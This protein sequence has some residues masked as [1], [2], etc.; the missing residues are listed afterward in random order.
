MGLFCL[1]DRRVTAGA[2]IPGVGGI[3]APLKGAAPHLRHPDHRPVFLGHAGVRAWHYADNH[4][5]GALWLLYVMI[6]VWGADSGAYMFGK[7]FGKHKLAP[8][9]SPGKTWQGFFGGLLTAAVISWAY[10]VW[11]HLDVTPTVLLVCSVVAALASVLGD[12]TE[13]CLSARPALRIAG[14]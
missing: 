9:V 6:L 2:L 12:L 11:A 10:G 14:T 3:L 7:M 13:V 1:V 8:K 5:S 4:Y